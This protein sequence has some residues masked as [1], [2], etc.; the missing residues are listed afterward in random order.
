[1]KQGFYVN[2]NSVF[3]YFFGGNVKLGKLRILGS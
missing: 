2:F 1:M 3:D